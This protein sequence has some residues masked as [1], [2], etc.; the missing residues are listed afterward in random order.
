MLSK[1]GDIEQA[2]IVIIFFGYGIFLQEVF[3]RIT[4]VNLIF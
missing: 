1:T 3:G 2:Q 4:A